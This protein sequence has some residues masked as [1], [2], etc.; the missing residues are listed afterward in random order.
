MSWMLGQTYQGLCEAEDS[1]LKLA[2]WE[3][4]DGK[5]NSIQATSV[6]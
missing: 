6:G 3:L 1:E 5:V 4:G 2:W